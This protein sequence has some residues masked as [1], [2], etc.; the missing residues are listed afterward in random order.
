MKIYTFEGGGKDRNLLDLQG[1]LARRTLTFQQYAAGHD[2]ERRQAFHLAFAFSS[3]VIGTR[4][5]FG[6]FRLFHLALPA[7]SSKRRRQCVLGVPTV[8]RLTARSW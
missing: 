6:G 4:Y 2:P 7:C 8:A 3:F 1:D 5:R